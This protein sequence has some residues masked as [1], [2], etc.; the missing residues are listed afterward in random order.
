[1]LKTVRD[2]TRKFFPPARTTI[3]P[4]LAVALEKSNAGEREEKI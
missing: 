3:F 1:M 4:T 2:R